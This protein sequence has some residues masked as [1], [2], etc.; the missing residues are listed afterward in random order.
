[1]KTSK[2]YLQGVYGQLPLLCL[3]FVLLMGCK[4][5][6]KVEKEETAIEVKSEPVIE[7]VTQVMDFQSV[8]TIPSGWNTFKYIN[9]SKEPHFFLMDKYPEGKTIEDTEKEVGP[10][11]DAGMDLINEGKTDEGFAAFNKLPAWFFDVVFTGGS[12]LVSPGHSSTTTMYLEPGYYIMECY[13]KMS[14]GKF[15]SSMGMAKPI[16]VTEEE[17]TIQPPEATVA[18]SISST[19]G[20]TYDGEIGKGP[21][22]FSVEF[23]DQIA[24]EN[25]VGH[26]INLVRLDANSDLDALDAWMNWLD[27]K[28]LINPAP[29]GFTFLGGVN[30]MPAGSKGYFKVDLPPG[31]YAFISEVPQPRSKNM[32]KT[33]VVSE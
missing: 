26:D 3:S 22:T 14:N 15:H 12:G 8:D 1:M 23:K 21:Q 18:L 20:I 10:A 11:F 4:S 19:E 17:S 2:Q 27:P 9:K 24:H 5:D 28:G 16:I 7:I 32:L 31:N 30:D 25:F 29:E 13:V 33:F 6:K